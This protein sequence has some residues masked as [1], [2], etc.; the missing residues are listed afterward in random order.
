MFDQGTWQLSPESHV[1]ELARITSPE[2][3]EDV[4]KLA[5]RA[6][7]NPSKDP[8]KFITSNSDL[9][10]RDQVGL[11]PNLVQLD[12]AGPH[13]P[14]LTF[15]DLPGVFNQTADKSEAHLVRHVRSLLKE[16][17]DPETNII[18]LACAMEN[19]LENSTAAALTENV[20]HRCVGLLTKADR[21]PVGHPTDSWRAVLNGETF[22]LKYGY[23]VTKQPN[24]AELDRGMNHA[25]AREAEDQFFRTTHPWKS[26]FAE[27]QPRFGIPRLQEKLSEIL[28]EQIRANVP[29][30]RKTVDDRLVFIEQRLRGLPE[31][32]GDSSF[33]IVSNLIAELKARL[34]KHMRGELPCHTFLNAWLNNICKG[35][36][37]N[38]LESRP[39]LLFRTQDEVAEKKRM[40]SQ[41]NGEEVIEIDVEV[42]PVHTP[43]HKRHASSDLTSPYKKP[44]SENA[45]SSFTSTDRTNQ[46]RMFIKPE[47][48]SQPA[49]YDELTLAAISTTSFHIEDVRAIYE[50]MNTSA[51]VGTT[52]HRAEEHL[53]LKSL[54]HWNH[55][56]DTFVR[57]TTEHL[58]GLV[59]DLCKDLLEPW[60]STLLAEELPTI[61][62][63]FVTDLGAKHRE[64]AMHLLAA[65]QLQPASLNDSALTANQYQESRIIRE[66]RHKWRAGLYQDKEELSKKNGRMSQGIEREEKLKKITEEQLGPD[67]YADQVS[68]MGKVRAY[69]N[70]ASA[71]LV[72]SMMKLQRLDLFEHT[73]LYLIETVV[74]R[75]K[76]HEA[77]G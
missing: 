29:R 42:E 8:M 72:D 64:H 15:Y 71:G 54:D 25:T 16:Y 59:S 37:R 53:I 22:Q 9:P 17:I 50:Q 36:R 43:R 3:L 66:A 11:S 68:A 40:I 2:Q 23:Y 34:E 31:P 52:D 69:Y 47:P 62:N 39:T 49:F 35:F 21:L 48:S 75:L 14:N 73:R 65:E 24:Q 60:Q 45:S 51:V 6:S 27:F 19:D 20:R 4:L 30:L 10:M 63:A 38:L 57:M 33:S 61:I 41:N 1:I 55:S 76:I 28:V 44:R 77:Q 58:R 13:C 74:R 5:Q 18:L 67:K 26:T 7:L 70:V 32:P 46:S 12:I 56:L